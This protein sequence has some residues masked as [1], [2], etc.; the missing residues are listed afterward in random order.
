MRSIFLTILMMIAVSVVAQTDERG[1]TVSGSVQ[2]VD[3]KEPMVQAT[4]Q[5]F[6]QRDST[7]VGGTVTDIRGNFSLVAPANGIYRV[8]VSSVGYQPIQRE[9]TL[10]RNQSVDLGEL[11]MSAEAVMLKEAVV[12]GR[13]AQVIVKKDTLVYNP[14]AYRTPEG[15]PIEELIKRIPGAEVDEDGNITINGKVV[16]KILLDGKEFMLGDVE[17][18]LKNLPVSIIQNMKF[19]DQQSDQARITGIEDGN[20]E[21]VIDFTIKKGMNRGYM[22]NLDI[23]GGTEH[24]YASRG[25]GS[26]FTDKTR[27]VLMGNLNNKEENAGWWNRRGLNARKMLGTNLNYDDGDKLKMDAS[28]RWNHRDGD[29]M[30]E[31][32]ARTSTARPAGRSR[33]VAQRVSRAVTTGTATSAWSGN[34]TR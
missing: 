12:T 18:A 20:K 23:A 19:Y 5:L 25:M 11:L 15:S 26:V 2:D 24:R 33:T 31:T 21:T 1:L 13:A 29:N 28:V 32:P 4:V 6:R 10:R 8:K 30:N 7:F 9:V 22:T 27:F 34:L 14:D 16:K 17:T 3:L